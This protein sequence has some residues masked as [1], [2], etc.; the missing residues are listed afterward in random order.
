MDLVDKVG[1][2]P[3]SLFTN[4]KFPMSTQRTPIDELLTAGALV[5]IVKAVVQGED[6]FAADELLVFV[7]SKKEHFIP[8]QFE[9]LLRP[10]GQ[11]FRETL[12]PSHG[13][14]DGH[15]L[16][17]LIPLNAEEMKRLSDSTIE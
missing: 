16:G 9:V 12:Q 8:G 10:H 3:G 2:E 14:P 1:G 6:F 7:V 4:Y 17:K 13:V 5:Y 11:G 15:F